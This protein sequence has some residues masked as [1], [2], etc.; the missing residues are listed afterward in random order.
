V[1]PAVEW[2]EAMFDIWSR[3]ALG[4][5]GSQHIGPMI[6]LKPDIEACKPMDVDSVD[7]KD[8]ERMWL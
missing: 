1:N 7:Y 4:P 8:T 2:L 6:T 3:D 5:T